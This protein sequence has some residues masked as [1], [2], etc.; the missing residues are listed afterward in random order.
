MAGLRPAGGVLTHRACAL[1]QREGRDDL[2]LWW[3][4]RDDVPRSVVVAAMLRTIR[5]LLS[6]Q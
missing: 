6:V 4:D 5:G 3:L 2:A 1:P